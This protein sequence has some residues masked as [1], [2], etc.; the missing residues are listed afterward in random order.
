MSALQTAPV[1]LRRSGPGVA[2]DS[3]LRRPIVAASILGAR[4]NHSVQ[5]DPFCPTRFARFADPFCPHFFDTLRARNVPATDVQDCGLA[6]S[7]SGRRRTDSVQRRLPSGCRF[8]LIIDTAAGPARTAARLHESTA[9]IRGRMETVALVPLT[10][11]NSSGGT[12]RSVP[13]SNSPICALRA[14]REY[15]GPVPEQ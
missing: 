12:E 4:I 11:P 6:C 14:E 1:G 10:R 5:A 9:G 7:R 15:V 3:F 2:S 13:G 8:R